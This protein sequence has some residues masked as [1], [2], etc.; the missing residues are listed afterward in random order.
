MNSK[1]RVRRSIR[2][3]PVDRTPFYFLAVPDIQRAL[4]DRLGIPSGDNEA[5]L[6]ALGADV[7][8]VSPSLVPVPGEARYGYEDLYE[9]RAVHA[10]MHNTAGGA[11]EIAFPV[12]GAST[13]EDLDAWRWPDPDWFDY[14]IPAASVA[15][16][17]E[18]AVVAYEMG[19]LFLFASA[20]RGMEMMMMDMAADPPMAHAIITRVADY[21]WE[22]S[23]RFLDANR[24]VIDILGIGDDVAGQDGM[25]ISP[26]P[27][28]NRHARGSTPAPREPRYCG[29]LARKRTFP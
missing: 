7:R 5:L 15:A 11:E 13:V 16:W 23:R 20:V 2:H 28:A 26:V 27:P 14:S 25:L 22:R 9:S 1:E 29:V 17:Q 10:R 8:Y 24:G 3:E 6:R 19:V 4:A 12:G 21:N 18:K